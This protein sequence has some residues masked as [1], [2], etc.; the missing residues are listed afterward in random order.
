[1][2]FADG[3]VRFRAIEPQDIE[4]LRAWIND[5]ETARYLSIS[6]PVSSRDQ[7]DYFERLRKDDDKKKLVIELVEGVVIGLLNLKNFDVANRSVEVGITIGAAEYRRKGLAL[8]SLRLALHV[9][10]DH[11]NYH[12]VWA[13]ILETNVASLNLF[14][15]AGFEQEG[16]LRESVYWDGRMIGP[17]IMAKLRR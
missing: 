12:R 2:Q 5:P 1:M 9:L 10:F 11:F 15:H 4:T 14:K 3:V 7:Q 8:R 6:W 17:V 13:H 16:V